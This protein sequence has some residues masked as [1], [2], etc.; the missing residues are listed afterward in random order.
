LFRRLLSGESGPALRAAWAELGF[1]LTGTRSERD[2]LLVLREMGDGASQEGL[3]GQ[4]L[5]VVAPSRHSTT[6]LQAPHSFLDADTADIALQLM[7]NKNIRAAAWN[8]APAKAPAH[9]ALLPELQSK[10]AADF[11][12]A[13]SRAL[14]TVL[15]QV[16]VVQLHSYERD[17][18][19]TANARHADLILSG[20]GK[21]P[22]QAIGRL[23][24]CLKKRLDYTVR[25]FPFEVQEM[26]AANRMTGAS[27]N[28]VGEIMTA[29]GSEG[30]VHLAMS[31]PFREE[32]RNYA[33]VRE[34][35]Y[36]CLSEE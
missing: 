6:V 19:Y 5:F 34:N 16:R 29:R 32:M 2:P 12:S 33:D 9:G 18:M 36:A 25:M 24:R 26:G 13:F 35:L 23:D 3:T 4:G 15:P 7:A 20:Y 11:F 17:K 30:F 21:D 28:A 10:P 22:S 8:T 27:Y 14:L 31:G 1:E